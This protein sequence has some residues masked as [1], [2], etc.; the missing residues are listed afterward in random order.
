MQCVSDGDIHFR[1]Q[2]I[3]LGHSACCYYF[4]WMYLAAGV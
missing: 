1:M 3:Y 2:E 4:A